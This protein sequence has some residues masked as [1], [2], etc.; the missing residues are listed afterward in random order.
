MS[1]TA[2]AVTAKRTAVSTASFRRA[3]R[4]ACPSSASAV[5]IAWLDDRGVEA[6]GLALERRATAPAAGKDQHEDGCDGDGDQELDEAADVDCVSDDPAEERA[7][8]PHERRLEHADRLAAGDDEPRERPDQDPEQRPPEQ[9]EDEADHG[10]AD[11]EQDDDR[12]DDEQDHHAL[13][14]CGGAVNPP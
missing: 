12:E 11:D 3:R 8:D 7:A 10:D 13:I 2:T 14:L 4:R 1:S 9:L 5:A 6:V